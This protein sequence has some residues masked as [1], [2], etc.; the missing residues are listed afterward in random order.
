M[1]EQYQT[2][3]ADPPWKFQRQ[4]ER[5]R[6]RYSLMELEAIKRVPVSNLAAEN[7]HL[8]L[9]VPNAL[10]RDGLTVMGAWGFEY[11]T[12]LTWAKYSLGVGNY[13]RNAT[14]Q[15]LFGIKGRL[16]SL[17]KNARTWFLADRR[18]HSRKPD[19]FYRIV[20]TMSPGPRIDIF[21]RESRS[22]W[23][24]WGN[25][26]D[27]FNRTQGESN[28]REQA[29]ETDG[30]SRAVGSGIDDSVRLDERPTGPFSQGRSAA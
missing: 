17:R 4:S 23:D 6:P 16:P 28:E 19:E 14:E 2:I 9:W 21:S 13:F 26:C 15:V 1:M 18:E 24:Q 25:E 11:K 8:Y 10:I 3:V 7:S 20:E 22:G 5:I 27:F 29:V 12:L 30:S